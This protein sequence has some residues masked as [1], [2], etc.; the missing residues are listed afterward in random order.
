MILPNHEQCKLIIQEMN[1]DPDQFTDWEQEFAASNAKRDFFTDRQRE[2][3]HSFCYKYDFEC[4]K[5]HR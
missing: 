1:D 3:I 4:M 5:G 2:I